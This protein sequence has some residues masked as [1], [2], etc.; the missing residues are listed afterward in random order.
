M[1]KVEYTGTTNPDGSPTRQ[2]GTA[3]RQILDVD[4]DWQG[5]FNTR[6]AYKGFDLSLVGF[7]RHGGI[8]VSN[9]HGPNGYL[10]LLTG[11]RNNID[12]DYWTATNTGAKY[13]NPAGPIS[14]DNPKYA[15][16]LAYF[17][18]S[19]L[20][21]R[22]ITLGYDFNRK[23]IKNPDIKL[24]MYFTAQNPFVMFSPFNKESGLDP[25]TNSVANGNTASAGFAIPNRVLTVG[26]NTPATRNFII[27]VNLNF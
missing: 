4:P 17:D 27:G 10:N 11:R 3:D 13:P 23:L 19:F 26:F 25:E 16:T 18:G 7:Y 6:V 24:R 21:I 8:L 5:G 1:I 15:S 2:I 9:I 20:K 22:T 12:V 14:G